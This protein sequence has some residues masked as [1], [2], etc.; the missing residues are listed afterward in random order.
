RGDNLRRRER[1]TLVRESARLD[2]VGENGEISPRLHAEIWRLPEKYRTPIILFYL[3]GK[4][5]EEAARQLHWP[6]G[7]VK[8]RLARRRDILRRRLSRFGATAGAL[9]LAALASPASVIAVPPTLVEKTVAGPVC[10]TAAKT[11]RPE[12]LARDLL[13]DGFRARVKAW[14]AGSALIAALAWGCCLL[15][16][17]RGDKPAEDPRQPVELRWQFKEGQ[18]FFQEVTTTTRQE[19]VVDGKK[20]DQELHMAYVVR[21]TPLRQDHDGTWILRHEMQSLKTVIRVGDNRLKYDSETPKVN[22]GLSLQQLVEFT[23]IPFTVYLSS[24][25]KVHRVDGLADA[26]VRLGRMG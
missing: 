4:T 2:E 20:H 9:A 26:W 12:I 17:G 1:E 8:G 21:W 6:L 3:Q 5:H 13:R 16:A 19:I 7:T 24:D 14:I 18:E 10:G 15:F 23:K 11:S 22:D 25:G